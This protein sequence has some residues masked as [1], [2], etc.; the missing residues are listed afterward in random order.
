MPYLN[1]CSRF[2]S[3]SLAVAGIAVAF[4]LLAAPVAQAQPQQPAWN[5]APGP[6]PGMAPP[7]PPPPG[8]PGDP[9]YGGGPGY[10]HPGRDRVVRCES[11]NGRYQECRVPFRGHAVLVRQLS[12]S[13]CIRGRTYGTTKAGRIWVSN[14]CRG[15]FAAR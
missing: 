9:G 6:G 2:A 11:N 1:L 8:R 5:G 12:D 7:P 13:R 10:G 3:A 15:D 14:G 4:A